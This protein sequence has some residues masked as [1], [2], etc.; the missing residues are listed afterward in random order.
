MMGSPELGNE[1]GLQKLWAISYPVIL[2]EELCFIE[3]ELLLEFQWI[4]CL[5]VPSAVV[6]MMS[7][8]ISAVHS[9]KVLLCLPILLAAVASIST[10]V[11]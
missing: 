1:T 10:L 8:Q 5:F 7:L 4:H 9:V 6:V 3:L 2:Q 11:L